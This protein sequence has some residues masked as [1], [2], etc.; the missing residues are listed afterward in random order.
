[1]WQ[2]LFVGLIV[3]AAVAAIA[4]CFYRSVTGKG[5][6]SCSSMP[7]CQLDAPCETE[8]EKKESD[9]TAP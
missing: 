8:S 4:Y 7:N 3:A 6:C 1:M 2:H 5:G 9:A